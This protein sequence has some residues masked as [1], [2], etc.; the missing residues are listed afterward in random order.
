MFP[1]VRLRP[2]QV[3]GAIMQAGHVQ[4]IDQNS[5]LFVRF[6]RAIGES[7]FVNQFGDPG[8]NELENRSGTI[9]QALLRMNG[10]MVRNQSNTDPFGAAG[11]IEG[12]SRSPERCLENCYLVCLTRKPTPAEAA[13]FL[14][15][16]EQENGKYPDGMVQDIFW[17][18][19][20][21]PEFSWNH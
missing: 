15:Q 2:E 21:S 20:N 3:V 1:L 17:T 19:F 12:M 6:Q 7:D 5:H 16:M 13:F 8:E 10:E 14:P 11:R 9:P 18:M 4:T